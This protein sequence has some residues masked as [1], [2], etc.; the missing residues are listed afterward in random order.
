MNDVT[1]KMGLV[2][3]IYLCITNLYTT[4]YTTFLSF[5]IE[6]KKLANMKQLGLWDLGIKAHRLDHHT[7]QQRTWIAEYPHKD[8]DT[9]RISCKECLARIFEKIL[10][11]QK[12]TYISCFR[13]YH[14]PTSSGLFR[15]AWYINISL[16]IYNHTF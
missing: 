4:L 7:K 14:D 2:R 6:W 16:H 8:T 11:W 1:F 9:H 10:L 12:I 13:L 15:F 5:L 3:A